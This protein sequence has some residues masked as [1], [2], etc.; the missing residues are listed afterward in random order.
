MTLVGGVAVVACVA[1]CW[2]RPVCV[3]NVGGLKCK[4]KFI[5]YVYV[6]IYHM[7]HIHAAPRV[8]ATFVVA[9]RRTQFGEKS[10]R[11]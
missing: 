2:Q 1:G 3:T 5:T 7:C 9:I 11:A 10:M 8:I 4:S 6:Y